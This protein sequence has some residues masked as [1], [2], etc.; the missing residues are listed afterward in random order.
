MLK[1]TGTLFPLFVISI[2]IFAPLQGKASKPDALP[3]QYQSIKMNVMAWPRMGASDMGCLFEKQFKSKD[4]MF[5]CQKWPRKYHGDPCHDPKEYYAGPEFPAKKEYMLHPLIT[6]VGIFYEGDRV[7][8][9]T[10][11]FKNPMPVESLK[12]IVQIPEKLPENVMTVD[13]QQ[14]GLHTRSGY[15][16]TVALFGF[17]HQGAA[18]VDCPSEAPPTGLK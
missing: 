9:V 18:D 17:D 12:R 14:G 16:N 1:R 8:S 11:T 15:A 6:Q 4:R 7:Q 2:L 13:Y 3:P 5:N 10:L